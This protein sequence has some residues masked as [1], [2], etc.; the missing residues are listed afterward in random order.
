MTV[1][2]EEGREKPLILHCFA[3]YGVESE[4][5]QC[6][7]E[8]VRVGINARNTNESMAIKADAYEFPISTDITF[9]LGVFHPTCK[10]WATLTS[11]SGNP[12]DHPNQIPQARE[13]ADKYCTH[14]VIENKPEAPLNDPV[15][16]HGRM[17][18]LPIAYERA[19]ETSFRVTQPPRHKRFGSNGETAE[20]SPYFF[21]ERSNRWWASV[22]GYRVDRYPKEH[23]AKNS[24][25]ASYIHH[26]CRDWL[27]VYEDATGES[28]GR[29]DYSDYDA[30]MD[31]RRRKS[32]NQSIFEYLDSKSREM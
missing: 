17:F 19:F 22:K 16:L 14:Y 25:P 28:S 20:T 27:R 9:D 15:V 13:L 2:F 7:G 5:L 10:R 4:S 6:Y 26:I 23:M 21:S 30:E 31:K 24:I 29:P 1:E 18:G 8:V 12:E 32:E 3:D 11:L